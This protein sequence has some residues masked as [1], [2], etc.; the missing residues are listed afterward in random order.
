V[1]VD[2]QI[3]YSILIFVIPLH[4]SY[5]A[6]RLYFHTNSQSTLIRKHTPMIDIDLEIARQ[7]ADL[8]PETETD[9]ISRLL[10]IKPCQVAAR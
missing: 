8:I 7:D 3:P 4:P 2:H 1:D 9:H 5:L 10:A 6:S